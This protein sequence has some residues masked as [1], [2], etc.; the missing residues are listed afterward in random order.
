MTVRRGLGWLVLV[1]AGGFY[2]KAHFGILQAPI[3]ASFKN[4]WNLLVG[5]WPRGGLTPWALLVAGLVGGWMAARLLAGGPVPRPL[6]IGLGMLGCL[7]LA[8]QG[9]EVLGWVLRRPSFTPLGWGLSAWVLA[10][11]LAGIA[12]RRRQ[13][14][15]MAGPATGRDPLDPWLRGALLAAVP[16]GL[17]ALGLTLYNGVR[18][19][20][21]NAYHVVVPLQWLKLGSLTEPLARQGVYGP[22]GFEKFA[23]PGNGHLLLAIPLILGWDRVACLVQLPFALLAAWAVTRI[24]R[25]AGGSRAAALL[26]GLGFLSAPIVA[27]QA[28]VP[29]LD[30]MT[31]ALILTCLAL[32]LRVADA[33]PPPGRVL[34]TAGLA[35][36]LA[37]GTKTS[38]LAQLPLVA[39]VIAASA[40]TRGK[41]AEVGRRLGVFAAAALA[42]VAFWYLRGVLLFGNPIFP[43]G[44]EPFGLPLLKGTTAE[45]M[46]GYW[47]VGRMGM[48]SRWGWL[49]FPFL[50]PEYSDETGFGALLVGLGALALAFGLGEL[51]Q[52]LRPGRLG[53][54]LGPRGRL[55]LLALLGVVVFLLGTA[56][57]PRL[58]LADVGLLAALAAPAVDELGRG[59]RSRG[60]VGTT[61]LALT[62]VTSLVALRRMAPYLG[63]PE[64]RRESLVRGPVV[65]PL[66]DR[67]PASVVFNDTSSE[68]E[69]QLSNAVLTGDRHQHLVYDDP[70]LV[71]DDPLEFTRRLRALGVHY[72][73][74]KLRP[75]ARLPSRYRTPS[76]LQIGALDGA[77]NEGERFR[78][79][80]YR[81]LPNAP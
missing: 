67:L 25:D 43:L 62:L 81:L 77:D 47:D 64:S 73:Y 1:V 49:L 53:R 13:A 37:L 4:P 48:R 7:V 27:N 11:V 63:P 16:I 52:E 56:R 75:E 14:V 54:R 32:L 65:P 15:T 26:G 24:G 39:L 44:F 71:V 46:T 5:A 59:G 40:W 19:W 80:L 70:G 74:L 18:T 9:L 29:M 57:T 68:N 28:A 35:L 36:G 23:N 22:T 58:A 34:V 10:A 8:A 42:P 2:L 50:D 3:D 12:W 38:A 72:V 45:L 21:G 69:A 79:R 20:D 76:L 60:A 66:I 6:A 30:L 33:P 78:S 17:G 55:A 41:P 61:A 31:A 51:I